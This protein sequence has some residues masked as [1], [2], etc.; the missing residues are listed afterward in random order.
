[1]K[2]QRPASRSSATATT[3]ETEVLDRVM[4]YLRERHRW[5]FLAIVP[6]RT[7]Q[8]IG[9]RGWDVMLR[10]DGTYAHRQAAEDARDFFA[11][12]L[13]IDTPTIPQGQ[14]RDDI[15]STQTE[16]PDG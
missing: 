11:K 1:M 5:M 9:R 2:L 6:A 14:A 7:S 16:N 4:D 13:G 10:I 8:G 3:D 15:T 12:E